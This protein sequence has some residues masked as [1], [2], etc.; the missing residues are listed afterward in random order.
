MSCSTT[1]VYIQPDGGA[2]NRQAS[3]GTI[4]STTLE[5]NPGNMW[6]LLKFFTDN[7]MNIESIVD[8]LRNVKG[9]KWFMTLFC[10][11]C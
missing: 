8:H 6:D 4:E 11:I 7:Q 3:G 9:I 10:E 1:E 2:V 5:P